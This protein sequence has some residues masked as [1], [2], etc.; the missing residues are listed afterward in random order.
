MESIFNICLI[1]KLFTPLDRILMAKLML[2]AGAD[3]FSELQ[4]E[5]HCLSAPPANSSQFAAQ[6]I[7]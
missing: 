3:L 1:C 2:I 7:P 6:S 5:Q 4:Q